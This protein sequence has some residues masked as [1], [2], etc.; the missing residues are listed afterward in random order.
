MT[1]LSYLSDGWL[2]LESD[3]GLFTLLIEDFG[4]KNIQVEEIYD[5]SKVSLIDGHVYGFIFLFKWTEERRSRHRQMFAS[6]NTQSL[7]SKSRTNSG[8]HASQSG[9]QEPYYVEDEN[10][11]NSIFFAHQIVPNSC[12]SHALLS[13][14]LNCPNIDLGDSLS[15]LKEMSLMMTPENKGLAISNLPEIA[16]AHNS[17]ASETEERNKQAQTKANAFPRTSSGDSFHF[18]SFVNIKNRVYELDGLKKF[19]IDHGPIAANE[20]FSEK[21][22]KIILERIP[23][24]QQKENKM[25]LQLRKLQTDMNT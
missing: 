25:N 22:R 15:R 7:T 9:T 13:V 4:C 10:L 23:Q 20:S 21:F 19:P 16:R 11:V 1:N 17:H 2:E 24:Q 12:A 18:I 14:L 8:E 5:L 6:N 3:P